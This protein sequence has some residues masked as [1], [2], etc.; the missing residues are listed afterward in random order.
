MLAARI[1]RQA[2]GRDTTG[3]GQGSAALRMTYAPAHPT[4][5][6]GR[7]GGRSCGVGVG[8]ASGTPA[9]G[10]SPIANFASYPGTSGR[11]ADKSR[12]AGAANGVGGDT[13]VRK[14][15]VTDGLLRL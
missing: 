3:F 11:T 14:D 7:V 5:G 2:Q 8:A 10:P 6:G 12:V 15:A 13:Q 9:V 1:A 4:G